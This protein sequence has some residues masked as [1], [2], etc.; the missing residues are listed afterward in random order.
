MANATSVEF[1]GV[2]D[3]FIHTTDLIIFSE[4]SEFKSASTSICRVPERATKGSTDLFAKSSTNTGT[5]G[6]KIIELALTFA[7]AILL[8]RS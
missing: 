6:L 3:I 7:I 8:E 2:P 1:F 4:S 5:P